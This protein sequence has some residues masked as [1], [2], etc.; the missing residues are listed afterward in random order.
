[1]TQLSVHPRPYAIADARRHKRYSALFTAG[2][3]AEDVKSW[4]RLRT[5]V[6]G[7]VWSPIVF[8]N[9]YRSGANFTE[10][11]WFAID[12][13]EPPY[14]LAQ[15]LRD[16]C[17]TVHLIGTTK[18]HL[19]EK[20]GKPPCDR[21]RII[22]PFD[23]VI[24]DARLYRAN[25]AAIVKRYD[26]DN[27]VKDAARLYF[28]CV[29]IVSECRAGAFEPLSVAELP[30]E[31]TPDEY[32]AHVCDK[33][34]RHSVVQRWPPWLESFL[35]TGAAPNG[36]SRHNRMLGAAQEMLESGMTA[37]AVVA[38]LRAVPLTRPFE[39]KEVERI[40]EHKH[41]EIMRRLSHGRQKGADKGAGIPGL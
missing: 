23:T 19:R 9:G 30:G 41:R 12:I 35:A 34:M 24:R 5:I 39:P 13:D 20:D 6:T 3:Q 11:R 4:A 26:A 1:M 22:A 10:A 32:A 27:S 21:F 37:A 38:A 14:T 40:V 25:V 36:T 15:A 16:W 8:L 31:P 2:W 17:D 28:P 7:H 29:E 33:A 18:S